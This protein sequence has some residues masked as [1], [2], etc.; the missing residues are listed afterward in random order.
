ML[1]KQRFFI[2]RTPFNLELSHDGSS[3]DGTPVVLALQRAVKE[4]TWRIVAV[5]K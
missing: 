4:Q 3:K 5:E 1:T 2:P